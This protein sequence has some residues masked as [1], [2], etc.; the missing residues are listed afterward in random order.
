MKHTYSII[1]DSQYRSSGTSSNFEIKLNRPVNRVYSFCIDKVSIPSF[2]NIT[3]GNNQLEVVSS[4]NK[5]QITIEPGYYNIGDLEN[6]LEDELS[7]INAAISYN[8]ITNKVQIE[9]KSA[10]SIQGPLAKCLGFTKSSKNL[11]RIASDSSINLNIDYVLIKSKSLCK[12][13][14]QIVADEKLS[15][16]AH[17]ALVD[18]NNSIISTKNTPREL[19]ARENFEVIDFQ[20]T[21]SGGNEINLNGCDWSCEIIFELE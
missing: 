15:D 2:Y 20:L 3:L 14:N 5:I 12:K 10:I 6:V 16:V 1:I 13:I 4:D 9:A 7:K 8:E 18:R 21:D 11:T 19:Y 17:R